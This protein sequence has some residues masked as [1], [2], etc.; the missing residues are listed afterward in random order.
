LKDIGVGWTIVGHSERRQF[1]HESDQEVASKV[2]KAISNGLK[3]ILC[4][5]ENI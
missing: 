4:I 1:F 5:G 2:K 3:V